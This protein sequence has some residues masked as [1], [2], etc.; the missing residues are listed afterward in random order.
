MN[1]KVIKSV[2]DIRENQERKKESKRRAYRTVMKKCLNKMNNIT[3]HDSD[4]K[5][6]FFDIPFYIE[7]HCVYTIE[8]CAAYLMINLN[9]KGFE[10]IFNPPNKLY[11]SWG[12]QSEPKKS[13][14]RIRKKSNNKNSIRT[15]APS[16]AVQRLRELRRR[17]RTAIHD[18]RR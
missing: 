9:K 15:P 10:T 14:K 12:V 3:K 13:P 18:S 2:N 11:I 5:G 1:R 6:M 16:D 4:V 8:E 7:G 17:T